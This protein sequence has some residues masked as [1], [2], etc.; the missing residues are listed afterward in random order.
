MRRGSNRSSHKDAVRVPARNESADTMDREVRFYERQMAGLAALDT[1]ANELHVVDDE[2]SALSW[3]V[4]PG[5][6][7]RQKAPNRKDAGGTLH[8]FRYR[9]HQD[10]M[11]RNSLYLM[12]NSILQAGFG[13][14]FWIIAAHLF[15]PSEV[16]QASALISA[17]TVIAYLALLGLNNGI[18]KYLPT[19]IDRD[20]LISSGLAMVA[21]FGGLIAMIYVQ[22]TPF[23]A[24]SLEFIEQRPELTVGFALITATVALNIL[25]D[26]VFIAMRKAGYTAFVDGIVAGAGKIVL[27]VL[28][29]GTGTY[30]LFLAS[31]LG[32]TLAAISSL[33]LIY[34]VMRCRLSLS[35]PIS[36]LKPLLIF[37]SANYVGNVANMLPTLVVPVI[38]LDRL[39]AA[40]AAYYYVVFQVV[41]IL[42]AAALAIEQTFLAEGSRDNAD[43]RRLK[44]RSLRILVS[45]CLPAAVGL[46]A[47][48]RWLLLAFGAKYY[49]YGWPSFVLLSIAAG[50]ITA[51]Y[52]CVTVLRLE[53]K[54]R[55]IILVNVTYATA[56]CTLAWFGAAHGLTV[57]AGAW[58]VGALIAALVAIMAIPHERKARHR[59]QIGPPAPSG[60]AA[61]GGPVCSAATAHSKPG[62]TSLKQKMISMIAG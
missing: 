7:T 50:P 25:T 57:L 53:G 17:A 12:S 19:A 22:L 55:A 48:G 35:R 23:I 1:L 59:R 39:G 37:S 61:K 11:A 33:A 32:T 5:P 4:G 29:V 18:G 9:L 21:I 8:A 62:P 2:R 20:A 14:S 3:A 34:T 60:R 40:A 27:S 47:I 36:T 6:R 43:L 31:A 44:W 13:F 38:V 26:S 46:L 15:K 56:V 51:I 42:Y 24:P 58:P 30:G 49:H 28:L 41:G 45:L 16:G 54:L 52:W 10:H